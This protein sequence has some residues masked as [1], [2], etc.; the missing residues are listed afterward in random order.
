[1]SFSEHTIDEIFEPF[2]DEITPP[3]TP[4]FPVS[5]QSLPNSPDSSDAPLATVQKS[6]SSPSSPSQFDHPQPTFCTPPN[7]FFPSS[8]IQMTTQQQ[9][10]HLFQE[11]ILLRQSIIGP[12]NILLKGIEHLKGWFT[13]SWKAKIDLLLYTAGVPN[14]WVIFMDNDQDNNPNAV[15]IYFLNEPTKIK[16]VEHLQWVIQMEYKNLVSIY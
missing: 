12:H 7:R 15:M 14:E 6:P 1:M 4:P 11:L 16:A 8:W 10:T 3:A 13:T 2:N 5:S 9:I